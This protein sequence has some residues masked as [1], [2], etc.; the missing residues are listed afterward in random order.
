[1]GRNL[2][3]II[4]RII[5]SLK[6]SGLVHVK[7]GTGD[8]FLQRP[9]D[10]ISLLDIYRAVEV[11]ERDDL[12]NFHEYPNPGYPVGANIETVMS[13]IESN[14]SISEIFRI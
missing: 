13:G 8:T 12:F 4:R 5:G 3:V 14:R 9:L 10:K 11:V 2:P 7:A 6:K 1:L